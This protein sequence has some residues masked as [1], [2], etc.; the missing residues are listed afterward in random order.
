MDLSDYQQQAQSTDQVAQG[1]DALVVPLLGL[2]GE[3]GTLLSEY[4]K[5]LRDGDAH[6]LH[7]ERVAEELGDLLWYISNVASKYGLDLSLIA[8]QNLAKTHG[9]WILR[10]RVPSQPGGAPVFDAGFPENERLPRRFEAEIR[11]IAMDGKI[12]VEVFVNSVPFGERLTDNAYD[13]DGYRFH[14][15]FHLAYAAVLGWSPVT[16]KL[17]DRKRKSN[18]TTDEVE[19][20]GRAIAI[21][22]G[23]SALVFEYAR[24][25]G[26]LETVTALDE[27]LIR[28]ILSFTSHLEVSQCSAGDWEV[29]VLR[30][31]DVWRGLVKHQGGLLNIDLEERSI[32]LRST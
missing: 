25:H 32:A 13:P 21:E 2:A 1:K 4:K 16:R 9:R 22:E 15:A 5:F 26:F 19:D 7:K 10:G 11:E 20:G 29:A 18:P 24:V 3:A 12:K 23:L 30:G 28:A 17:L 6:A 8:E 31:F 14:D 27:A